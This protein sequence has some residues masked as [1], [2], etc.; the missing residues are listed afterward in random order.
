MKTRGFTLVELALSVSILAILAAVTVIVA[1]PAKRIGQTYDTQRWE[2]VGAL[3]KAV[4]LYTIDNHALPSDLNLAYINTGV[5][6]T[7]CG[8]NS[9]YSRTCDG[10]TKY[11]IVFNDADFFGK[12]LPSLPLDPTKTSVDDSGYYITRTDDNMMTF[13]ACNSYS[14]DDIEVVARAALPDFGP[15]CGNGEL[16]AGELCD[17]FWTTECV[18][19]QGYYTSNYVGTG[20]CRF[21]FAC[22]DTCDACEINCFE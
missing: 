19:P 17:S 15:T 11:C 22:S 16:E 9:K 3:A 12:Y 18:N 10:T 13:G 2:E 8:G 14:G 6:Y 1:N 5:K 4:E 7:I 20:A 21:S